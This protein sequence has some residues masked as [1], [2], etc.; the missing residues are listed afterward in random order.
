MRA[1]HTSTDVVN[2]QAWSG[3]GTRV[4]EWAGGGCRDGMQERPGRC[5]PGA[6]QRGIPL[7]TCKADARTT[8][9][10]D[11]PDERQRGMGVKVADWR[12][13][14]QTR[15]KNQQGTSGSLETR[16]RRRS[17]RRAG[18]QCRASVWGSRGDRG[19][20]G[21]RGGWKR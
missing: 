9:S 14:G 17:R 5:D 18:R 10:G 15:C 7:A 4:G 6:D 12:H 2:D 19:W 11:S 1:E 8:A 3:E 21:T 16:A 20:V 13:A